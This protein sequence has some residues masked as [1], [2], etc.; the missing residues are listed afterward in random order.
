MHITDDIIYYNVLL[1]SFFILASQMHNSNTHTPNK[2][3]IK[4]NFKYL[5]L[6]FVNAV[7][8]YK[9]CRNNFL[10]SVEILYFTRLCKKMLNEKTQ[11]G[12]LKL[13]IKVYEI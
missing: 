7:K 13:Q 6:Y 11:F 2:R 12:H 8:I 10:K 3:T 9:L 4:K 1:Q 5:N